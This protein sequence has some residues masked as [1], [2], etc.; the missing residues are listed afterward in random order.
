M[1]VAPWENDPL[2]PSSTRSSLQRVIGRVLH[3]LAS[4]V[5]LSIAAWLTSMPLTL[6]FFERLTPV[7][8]LA[9]IVVIPMTFLI[10][11]CGWLSLATGAVWEGFAVVFNNANLALVEFLVT[12]MQGLSRLPG[13]DPDILITVFPDIHHQRIP[14]LA[15]LQQEI[16]AGQF[17]AARG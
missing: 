11:V 1:W 9:N 12:M 2:V 10:V 16:F 3:Y 6:L 13:D 7:G 8:L 17:R 5:A 14:A 4:L 15:Q